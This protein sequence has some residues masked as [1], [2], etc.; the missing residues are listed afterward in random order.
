MAQHLLE[1]HIHKDV[2]ITR[3]HNTDKDGCCYTLNTRYENAAISDYTW[4]KHCKTCVMIIN[5]D[6]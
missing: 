5:E 1:N 6:V 4:G 2:A 3:P